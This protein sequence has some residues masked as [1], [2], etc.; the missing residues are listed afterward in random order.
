MYFNLIENIV[1]S[2]I[3]LVDKKIIII[4]CNWSYHFRYF[5]NF[6]YKKQKKIENEN[7]SIKT[8]AINNQILIFNFN[9][10]SLF[11]KNYKC[12]KN[13]YFF[14]L[15]VNYLESFKRRRKE[16]NNKSDFENWQNQISENHT[17]QAYLNYLLRLN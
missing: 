16:E 6:N 8:L 1:I 15:F 13:Y 11:C 12:I 9:Q 4:L 17:S 5:E 7:H 10:L 2:C 3:E 14:S